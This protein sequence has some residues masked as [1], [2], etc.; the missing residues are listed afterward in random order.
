MLDGRRKISQSKIAEENHSTGLTYRPE[1]DRC[2]PATRR[3]V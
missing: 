2:P 1:P 3:T